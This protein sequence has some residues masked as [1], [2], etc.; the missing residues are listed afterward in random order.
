[1][2]AERPLVDWPA[3]A[4]AVHVA[5]SRITGPAYDR[6]EECGFTVRSTAPHLGAI[7]IAVVER[8]D[9]VVVGCSDRMLLA[10][11][12]RAR[13]QEIALLARVL[14]VVPSPGADTAYLAA[15][16]GF[17]GLVAREVSC[18]AFKRAI[19]AA[20]Q[21]E[22][23]FPRGAIASLFRLVKRSAKE[24]GAPR[25]RD[26]TPRQR[27]VVELIAQGATDREIAGVLGISESTAHKHVQNALR[28]A[29]ARTRSQLVART[30]RNGGRLA[31]LPGRA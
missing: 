8:G 27:Q 21:G 16:A 13:V 14:A 12:F 28:R 29:N 22:L 31:R 9:V 2:G 6:L 5:H 7:D 30:H 17:H 26:L 3:A 11:A 10:P 4:P 20:R 23:V 25:S 19:E 1:M 15:R 24:N 18:D